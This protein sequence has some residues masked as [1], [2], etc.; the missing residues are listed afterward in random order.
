MDFIDKSTSIIR[1]LQSS[2]VQLEL[3]N[4]CKN[5][6]NDQNRNSS[7]CGLIHANSPSIVEFGM[8][9]RFAIHDCQKGQM[10]EFHSDP[11]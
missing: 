2:Y 10:L 5:T 8:Q 3:F 7:D 9:Q 1:D 11:A 4:I 6:E